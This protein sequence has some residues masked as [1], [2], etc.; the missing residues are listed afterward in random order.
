MF[1]KGRTQVVSSEDNSTL[2]SQN[3][4]KGAKKGQ[5]GPKRTKKGQKGQNG[6]EHVCWLAHH[7]NHHRYRWHCKKCKYFNILI[8][9]TKK[10]RKG[11][12]GAKR[13]KKG[14]KGLQQ[15]CLLEDHQNHHSYRCHWKKCLHFIIL[16][17]KTKK[18]LKGPKGTKWAG[19]RLLVG[20]SSKSPS[21]S[22]S[23]QKM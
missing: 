18:G 21:L 5:K 7:R 13:G 4:T 23:L 14:Q 15:V 3:G 22:L 17:I 11:P 9:S 19:A 16:Q 2:M 20:T 10:V 8:R 12:K 1:L 6:L